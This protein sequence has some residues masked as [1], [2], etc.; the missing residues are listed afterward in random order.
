MYFFL[1]L[2]S[3]FYFKSWT[4]LPTKFLS[5][6]SVCASHLI[7]LSIR[8]VYSTLFHHLQNR[9]EKLTSWQ[10]LFSPPY[11][12]CPHCAPAVHST[13]PRPHRSPLSTPLPAVH[14]TPCANGPF[15]VSCQSVVR[16]YRPSHTY[17]F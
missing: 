12:H 7:L 8:L 4:K 11:A 9:Y 1:N 17:L 13:P 16:F 5:V 2:E 3:I 6:Q 10:G 15:L 14:S